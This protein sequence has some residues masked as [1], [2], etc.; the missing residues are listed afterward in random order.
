MLT[1]YGES[2]CGVIVSTLGSVGVSPYADELA[3][4]T[5][6]R[7]PACRAAS[8]TTVVPCTPASTVACGSCTERNTLGM[9]A[10]WKTTSTPRMARATVSRLDDAALD[11]LDGARAATARFSRRPLEKSSRMRTV[12]PAV[13]SASAMEEPMNPAPPVTK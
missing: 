6:L 13:S 2:G 9:A 1:A 3:A 11:E 8:S 4:K 10:S 12:S 5:T 7:T